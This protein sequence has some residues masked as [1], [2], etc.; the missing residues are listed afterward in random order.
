[1]I[2]G[3]LAA[4]L[5]EYPALLKQWPEFETVEALDRYLAERD[6]KIPV[7]TVADI[8]ADEENLGL[9]GSPTKVW[10]VDYVVL[11]TKES[12]QIPA[13]QEGVSALVSELI[14]GHIL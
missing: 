9:D 4:T 11:E 13:T 10:K 14:Q 1:M 2:A 3:K 6:Q 12:R 8:G 7:W 5:L